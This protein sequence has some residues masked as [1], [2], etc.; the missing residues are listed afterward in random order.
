MD[1]KFLKTQKVFIFTIVLLI[2]YVYYNFINNI[3]LGPGD[4]SNYLL[5]FQY[6]DFY[7]LLKEEFLM[8]PNRPV[9]AFLIS[10]FGKLFK[11]N[12]SYFAFVSFFI[13][14]LT[15]LF[16]N[17]IFSYCFK[18]N[19]SKV[20]LVFSLFPFF[21]LS[22]FNRNHLFSSFIFSIFLWSLGLFFQKKFILEKKK[23]YY[24]LF[25][26]FTL[27]SFFSLEYIFSLFPLNFFLKKILNNEEKFFDKNNFNYFI[28]PI[29]IIVILFGCYKLFILPLLFKDNIIYGLSIGWQ[30][31]LQS[32][33]FFYSITFENIILLISSLLFAKN[34]DKL[35]IL[36]LILILFKNIKVS[37]TQIKI[38]DNKI[39]IFSILSCVL[40]NS[41]IFFI[42]G[43]P[44][45]T[46]SYYNRMLLPTF[47]LFSIFIGF[48]FNYMNFKKKIIFFL[49]LSLSLYSTKTQLDN[50]VSAS[51]IRDTVIHDLSKKLKLL[52][53]EKN[54]NYILIANVPMF[55]NENYNNEEV[56][57]LK[58]DI[59]NRIEYAN[60]NKIDIFP[61][62]QRLIMNK[63]YYPNHNVFFQFDKNV[64]GKIIL[65][66]QYNLQKRE[67]TKIIKFT[68]KEIFLKNLKELKL[69]KINESPFILNEKI[70]LKL[71]N[72]VKKF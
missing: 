21:C 57:Y 27:I 30:S 9:S 45:V 64:D 35:I 53:L 41:F 50:F 1:S 72:I 62:S 54:N 5:K 36:I 59:T 61:I 58:W 14:I 65:Y 13:W 12:S 6:L 15:I 37:N 24:F 52:N 22:V 19:F 18:I 39:F 43:Y 2:I 11:L 3:G 16:I 68:N 25:I 51:K 32:I 26:F 33:Y 29:L 56:F 20:F 70:R 10:F 46:F 42:S 28:F 4:D 66:Y 71:K 49:I 31:F 38:L 23:I 55:L 47:L 17:N 63:N 60:K 67:S 44:S 34:L 7:S 8:S 48:Y 69:N 40:A